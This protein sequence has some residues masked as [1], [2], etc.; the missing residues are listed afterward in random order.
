MQRAEDGALQYVVLNVV[1]WT[2][3]GKGFVVGGSYTTTPGQ[4]NS[5]QLQASTNTG[6][7]AVGYYNG[8]MLARSNGDGTGAYAG[9]VAGALINWDPASTDTGQAVWNGLVVADADIKFPFPLIDPET[10]DPYVI[11]GNI[12]VAAPTSGWELRTQFMYGPKNPTTDVTI[13]ATAISTY[14]A[15]KSGSLSQCMNSS[16]AYENI[17]FY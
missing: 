7:D 14:L 15:A 10:G 12:R 6:T 16:N 2:R 17:L 11:P 13:V 8:Q 1:N 5:L 3:M 4:T 9:Q